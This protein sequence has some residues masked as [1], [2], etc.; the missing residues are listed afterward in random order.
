MIKWIYEGR[1]LENKETLF[2]LATSLIILII[3]ITFI[4]VRKELKKYHE[5]K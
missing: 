4:L 5:N 2:Y 1:F 3:V